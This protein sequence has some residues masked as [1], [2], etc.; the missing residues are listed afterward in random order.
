MESSPV[1]PQRILEMAW[2]YAPPLILESAVRNGLFDALE[3]EPRTLE[4]VAA[5]TGVSVRGAWAVLNA[6]V[7]FGFLSV[8]DGKYSLTAESSTFLVRGKP[9]YLGGFLHHISEQL[10][11]NWLKLAETSAAASRPSGSTLRRRERSSSSRS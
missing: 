3:K 4:E 7:G 1:S 10:I 5:T 9:G 6:L 2:G 11:P 8:A